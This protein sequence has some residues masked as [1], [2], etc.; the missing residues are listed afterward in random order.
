MI[1]SP[2]VTGDERKPETP[3]RGN[4]RSGDEEETVAHSA[5]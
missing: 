3:E 4:E 5:G 1:S 2:A